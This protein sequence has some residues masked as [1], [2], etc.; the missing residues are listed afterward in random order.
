MASSSSTS[1]SNRKDIL[2]YINATH[3]DCPIPLR[4][5]EQ[6]AWTPTN[7]GRR[8]KACPIYDK[9]KKC[10]LYG[11][12]D[13]EL[14][15]YYYKDLLYNTHEENKNIKNM[16]KSSSS[17]EVVD[18]S[19]DQMKKMME[20]MTFIKTRS[21]E[22]SDGL[23]AIQ[24]QL[25]NLGREIKKVNEKVY[26]AQVGCEKCKGAHYTKVCPL[27]VEEAYSY[28]AS[29]IDNSIPRKE[30][31][32]GSFTLPYYINNVYFDNAL[33]DLGAS[34]S[35]MPFSTY[36]NLGLGELAHNKLTVELADMTVKYPKGIAKNMLVGIG[37]FVFPVDLIILDMP[38]DVKVPLILERPFMSTA[39]P[40]LRLMYSKER[41]L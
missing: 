18:V 11:F 33:A 22:T 7:P 9:K 37:K 12:T 20:E 40:M 4:V 26:A 27:K 14:P 32:S 15:S 35:I 38:E 30:K 39:P 5:H 41:L 1:R 6:I 23:A 2:F 10:G 21:T 34:V 25:N 36:L 17:N 19:K 28:K 31:E 3:C 13:L 8:F 16:G 29:H 24:E